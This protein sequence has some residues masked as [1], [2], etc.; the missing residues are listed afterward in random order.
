MRLG[1]SRDQLDTS[2]SPTTVSYKMKSVYKPVIRA[3]ASS[4]A[5]KRHNHELSSHPADWP[6]IRGPAESLASFSLPLKKRRGQIDKS[7]QYYIFQKKKKNIKRNC[8]REYKKQ[9]HENNPRG[10]AYVQ[11]G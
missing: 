1:R 9:V 4:P 10:G 2:E 5:F 3:A 6:R 7:Q 11:G 8:N